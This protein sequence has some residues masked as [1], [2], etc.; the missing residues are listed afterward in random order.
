MKAD[1]ANLAAIQ[2]SFYRILVDQV[3]LGYFREV[4]VSLAPLYM[5]TLQFS[6]WVK[7]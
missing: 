7:N 6:V 3:T 4:I 5:K 1:I 2:L